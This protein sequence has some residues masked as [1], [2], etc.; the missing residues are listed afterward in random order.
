MAGGQVLGPDPGELVGVTPPARRLLSESGC[1]LSRC[2]F[3]LAHGLSPQTFGGVNT[4]RTEPLGRVHAVGPRH[5]NSIFDVYS[6]LKP[7]PGLQ[8]LPSGVDAKQFL[9]ISNAGGCFVAGFHDGTRR[10]GV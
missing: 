1:N 7:K 10:G 5:H 6:G 3:G 4:F 2:R 8:R 9:K